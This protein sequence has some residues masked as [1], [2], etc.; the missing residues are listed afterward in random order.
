M[1][2]L[3]GVKIKQ[4]QKG[5]I[6]HPLVDNGEKV[7]KCEHRSSRRHVA[8]EG[9]QDSEKIASTRLSLTGQNTQR[10]QTGR[11]LRKLLNFLLR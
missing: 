4:T 7:Q 3:S 11:R 9:V 1:K 8:G 2:Q 10:L 6:P 5:G